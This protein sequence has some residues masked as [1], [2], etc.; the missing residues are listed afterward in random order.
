MPTEKPQDE[1]DVATAPPCIHLRSKA[2][3]VTGQTE[4]TDPDES[5][6]DHCWCNQTQHVIG[7]DRQ[8]VDRRDCTPLRECYR[9]SY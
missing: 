2:M 9:A 3:Y 5:G 4:P 6:S 8:S 1:L 7:P